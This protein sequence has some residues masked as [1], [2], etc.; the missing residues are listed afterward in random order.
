MWADPHVDQVPFTGSI[1]FAWSEN[2]RRS[3]PPTG[4]K[5]MLL[6]HSQISPQKGGRDAFVTRAEA[7][8]ACITLVRD[9]GPE[10]AIFPTLADKVCAEFG[11]DVFGEETMLVDGD[12]PNTVCWN[13]ASREFLAVIKMMLAHPDVRMVRTTAQRY[14]NYGAPVEIFHDRDGDDCIPMPPVE[15]EVPEGGYS[16][17]HWVPTMFVWNGEQP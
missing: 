2:G 8:M 15:G 3:G 5:A 6:R 16:T 12:H 9:R 13:Y 7:V 1:E 11:M 17:P 10:G 4:L 14:Y